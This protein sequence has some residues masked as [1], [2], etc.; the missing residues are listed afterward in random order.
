MKNIVVISHAYVEAFTRAGLVNPEDYPDVS[1]KVIIPKYCISKSLPGYNKLK[2]EYNV[3]PLTT[4]CNFH[5]SVRFYSLGLGRMLKKIKPE[6]IFVNNEPWSSTAFQ[7]VLMRKLLE[8]NARIMVY[9]CENLRR[10]IPFPFNLMEKYVLRNI[11]VLL[12]L[13]RTEGK[14]VFAERGYK[15]KTAYL[16][17]SVDSNV[18]KKIDDPVLK[19]SFFEGKVFILGFAG[20]LVPEKGI[21]TIIKALRDLRKEICLIIIGEGPMKTKLQ[22]LAETMGVKERIRFLGNIYYEELPRYLSCLDTFLLP[23]LT[24]KNWKEQFGRVLIEAMS[25]EVPVI[26]SSSGEIPEVVGEAGLVF[27]ENDTEDLKEKILTLYNN[28][29]LRMEYSKRGREKTLKVYDRKVVDVR[30]CEL[31]KGDTNSAAY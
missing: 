15:G 14:E 3:Y 8:L 2:N 27:K 9:T 7:V 28:P 18:F 31:F 26:G 5:H 21:D 19:R 13:T 10:K 22:D 6:I 30:T 29:S 17:L 23:S 20:R 4:Y 24:T 11:D 12:T 16:P 1:T 25:C